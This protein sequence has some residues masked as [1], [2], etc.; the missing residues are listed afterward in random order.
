LEASY[1]IG[2]GRFTTKGCGITL[3]VACDENGY[4]IAVKRNI[5]LVTELFGPLE[6]NLA[7]STL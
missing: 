7:Q 4:A 5:F 6:G 1:D 2:Y 3:G